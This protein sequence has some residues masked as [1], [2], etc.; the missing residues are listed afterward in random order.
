MQD[1][2]LILCFSVNCDTT[3]YGES[4]SVT[5]NQIYNWDINRS[6][7]LK[8]TKESYPLWQSPKHKIKID[9]TRDFQY[10]YVI[11][12][13]NNFIRWEAFNQNRILILNNNVQFNYLEVSDLKF[14]KLA[15]PIKT[16][17]E[18]II[19]DENEFT[20]KIPERIDNHLSLNINVELS[21]DDEKLINYFL[22]QDATNNTW[23]KKLE[24]I[25]EL[26]NKKKTF[27]N[28]L[29]ALI[30]SYLFFINTAQIKCNE[31]G[32]HFRP[33]HHA[34]FAL[35]ICS[36]MIKNQTEENSYIIRSIIRELPS[37]SSQ[38]MVT[39]PFTRIRDIAHRNDIPQ[40]LK[41]EIKT[42]LQNK[43]HRSAAPEDL[44]T[45]EKIYK[46][47]KNGNYSKEFVEQFAIFYEELKE[48]F[49]AL[50]VD[51]VLLKIK[52]SFENLSDNI[53]TFLLT[54][55][56]YDNL[57]N[58]E[59]MLKGITQIREKLLEK[60]EERLLQILYIG[61][62]EMENYL[63]AYLSQILN[64]YDSS[65]YLVNENDL[66]ELLMI[67]SYCLRN[68]ILSKIYTKEC[69]IILIDLEHF[70]HYL[71]DN[72]NLLILKAIFERLLNIC[73]KFSTDVIQNY[74]EIVNVLG[75]KLQI[76]SNNVKIFSEAFIRTHTI[77]QLTKVIS[78]LLNYVRKQLK[79][80]PFI[81]ISLGKT[82]GNF[83]Q[84]D[85][86]S[87]FQTNHE[88][89]KRQGYI[90]FLDNSDGTE[91]L[92]CEVKG[93]ILAHEL[94]Q[95]SHLAIRSRQEK[96]VFVCCS[97]ISVYN[98]YLKKFKENPIINLIAN[99]NVNINLSDL[100]ELKYSTNITDDDLYK[101]DLKNDLIIEETDKLKDN[102]LLIEKT[103]KKICGSKS[104]N[105]RK[106]KEIHSE[107]FNIPSS[108]TIPFSTYL[109][110][111]RLI[112]NS[113]IIKLDETTLDKIDVDSQIFRQKFKEIIYE[114]TDILDNIYFDLLNYFKKDNVL[115]AIR[116]SSN[117]EDV[118][119][120]VGAG[121][122]DSIIGVELSDKEKF[123]EAITKVWSSVFTSRGI[124][125]RKKNNISSSLGR[126]GILIQEMI[127]AD[128]SFIIHTVNPINLNKN[129]IYI[130]LA[131]GLGET[132]ASGNL[133]GSPFR[134]TFSKKDESIEILNYSS[135]SKALLRS[136]NRTDYKN[137]VFKNEKLYKD[138]IYLNSI[139]NSLGKI[140]LIIEKKFNGAQDIEGCIMN[141]L[142][143][144][145]QTRPQLI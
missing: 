92:P 49:N 12:K 141:N 75:A 43:L 57:K 79:L 34:S 37:F 98:E 77:F 116:S 4:I 3:I 5:G 89:L 63:F 136:E 99:D 25:N 91:E 42:T 95:L 144:I 54:K 10:K 122:F 87:D 133:K 41:R 7:E 45:C 70:K 102:I 88:K 17:E 22:D 62:I 94:P 90:V 68:I 139:I 53:D 110:F 80:P 47:I 65:N 44:K 121:L 107:L 127:N 131:L 106:L 119:N 71:N 126:M 138:K 39:V 105:I 125:F 13:G 128:V 103:E 135:Y 114:Q 69:E 26:V 104:Y 60:L 51:K 48:F 120:N 132:L 28:K 59:K 27:S 142:F 101:I 82:E 36:V 112:D 56:N 86:M 72:E 9:N 140:A 118:S 23:K 83:L 93:I 46:S 58:P 15:S 30:S 67:I 18:N 143:Y 16:I 29:L 61:D 113:L 123:I 66:K 11:K 33:N 96:A 145:V 117:L 124:L 52:K 130:E 97:E 74:S 115:Y 85:T 38:Y 35:N 50:S 78:L 1:N 73:Y 76:P 64:K 21:N 134:F 2:F 108:L 32:T 100:K 55:N 84:L 31:D 111:F 129:E 19:I 20:E 137:V 14:D 81:I 8:T 109:K 6:I 40:D 24:F